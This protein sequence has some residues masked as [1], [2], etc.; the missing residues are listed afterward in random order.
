MVENIPS[1]T[2]G[3]TQVDDATRGLPY[4]NQ[5]KGTTRN[6]LKKKAETDEKVAQANAAVWNKET[7]Y[8]EDTPAGN[9][10]K[11]FD[12]YIKSST[13]A[14]SAGTGGTSSRRKATISDNDRLFSRSS[15][16]YWSSMRVSVIFQLFQLTSVVCIED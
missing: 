7:T 6:L 8:L 1:T 4:Y 11:G 2:G 14:G 13:T 12:G 3:E 5:I 15:T 9:I 10:L 16:G